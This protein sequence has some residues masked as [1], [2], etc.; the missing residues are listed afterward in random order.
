LGLSPFLRYSRRAAPQSPRL[1]RHRKSA[2]MVG[3]QRAN[4]PPRVIHFGNH[5]YVRTIDSMNW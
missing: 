5:T 4:T 1:M 3:Q 2:S